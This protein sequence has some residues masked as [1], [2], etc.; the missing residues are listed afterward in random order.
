M[1]Q[2]KLF[3]VFASALLLVSSS[4][5]L[6]S[7][8]SAASKTDVTTSASKAKYTPDKDLKGK[9]D[10]VIVGA[11]GAGMAAALSAKQKGLNPVILEKMPVAGGNTLKASSG[12]NA[13]ET[14]VEKANGVKDSNKQFYEETLK[15]GQ[16]TNNKA[17]LHYMVNHS[18]SAIDWLDSMGMKLD[19]LTI[20]GGM[21]VKRTHRPHDGSAVGQYLVN[22]LLR[23]VKEKKIPV[24]VNADVTKINEKNNK[25][26][27]VKVVMNQDKT[28]TISSK[29][30]IVTTGG[31]GAS[32]KMIK[33]YRP[34][35]A[36]YVTTNQAGSTGDGIKMIRKLG[37]YTVDMN[38]I[39]IHPTVYQK[40][41]YLIGE[42]TRGEGGILVNKQGDRFTNDM[43]TRDKVS[44]AINK[45]SGKMA[46]VL[47]D[48]GVKQRSS[49]IDEY[50][51]KGF[52][53]KAATV[54]ELAKEINVPAAELQK[55]VTTWNQAVANKKDTQFQ[56]TTGMDHQLNQGPYYAIPVAPGIHYT[57][58]GVKI[59]TKTQVL[60]KSGKAI[61]GLYAAGEVAGGLHGNN[62]I[63]GNSV[64]DIIVF[65]RQ[66][67][68]QAADYLK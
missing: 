56:R 6:V 26:S 33:Q 28:K 34:D 9:Y 42:A 2:G 50:E 8:V 30:V 60:K 55:T 13:S 35:L 57:M 22:G 49:A 10:V 61:P 36:K 37:G 63:G 45:Q 68:D 3:T 66:A 38:K 40:P 46:Y 31:F 24:F 15:G 53:K 44:A 18:A 52:T 4:L 59:N 54:E 47:F 48:A 32:K 27:G 5:G 67:G 58:G 41:P 19:K 51:K 29:A 23:N 17:L 14:K 16:Y 7:G 39:Q 65:G 20:S 25:V 64:A 21:S 12:M 62:R 1:K 43:S 11:G